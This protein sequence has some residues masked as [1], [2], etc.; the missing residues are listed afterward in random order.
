MAT[1]RLQNPRGRIWRGP[2]LLDRREAR[3]R[4]V[5]LPGSHDLDVTTPRLQELREAKGLTLEQAGELTTYGQGTLQALENG[6]SMGRL[7]VS[8]LTA[9]LSI[10]HAAAK[11]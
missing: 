5:E 4:G 7:Q 9:E 10:S 11:G 6:A 1:R 2:Q 8:R 3:V